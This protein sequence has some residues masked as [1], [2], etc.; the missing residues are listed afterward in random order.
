MR[1]LARRRIFAGVACLLLGLLSL[2]HG[3][4]WRS[5]GAFTELELAACSG[6]AGRA[7]HAK[8]G[9]GNPQP[10]AAGQAGRTSHEHEN[11]AQPLS[12]IPLTQILNF[13]EIEED[14]G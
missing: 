14:A 9:S 8:A 4:R 1:L 7:A 6:S 13:A 12:H 11:S 2:S 3:L 5:L 10:G